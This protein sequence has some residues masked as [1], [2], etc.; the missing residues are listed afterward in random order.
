MKTS[1]A[2]FEIFV[3]ECQFW[4]DFY[5]LKDWHFYFRHNDK[6]EETLA[7]TSVDHKSKSALITMT[8][9]WAADDI[10]SDLIEL[11]AHHEVCEVMTSQLEDLANNRYVSNQDYIEEA[12]HE[13]IT[14][15]QNSVWANR[16][17]LRGGANFTPT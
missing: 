1:K 10:T 5:G 7:Y 17:K 6:H 15:L 11:T 4:I 13:I 12:K 16:N 9:T 3:H 8:K 14:R 2:D